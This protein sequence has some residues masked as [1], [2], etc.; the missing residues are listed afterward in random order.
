MTRSLFR[1]FERFRVDYLLLGGQASIAYGAATFSED[2][3]VWVR[4]DPLNAQRLLQALAALRARVYKLTPPLTTGLLK[5]GHGFHFVIPARPL[6][7]YLDAMGRP[8]RAAGFSTARRRAVIMPTGM[9]KL[10]VV[11]IEDLVALKKTRRLSDY[12]VISNLVRVRLAA[13]LEPS[14]RLLEWAARHSFRAEDRRDFLVR[15]GESPSLSRCRKQIATE[16]TAHQT[17]DT[18]YWRKRIA[19]LRRLRRKGLLLPEGL[20]V[21]EILRGRVVG[22]AR[23]GPCVKAAAA[24]AKWRR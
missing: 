9:G 16:I 10:P 6:S 19:D 17:R 24:R 12:E 3:D 22:T 13:E 14:R 7:I 5:A 23:P 15:L 4:P 11:S 2:I 8:P 21:A 20:P 18:A 1:A